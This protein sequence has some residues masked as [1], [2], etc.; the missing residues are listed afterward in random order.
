MIAKW[1]GERGYGGPVVVSGIWGR[2]EKVAP[3]GDAF[4]D[5]KEVADIGGFKRSAFDAGFLKQEGGIEETVELKAAAA[6]EH[7][8]DLSSALVL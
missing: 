5:G 7:G 6:G 4:D 3:G 1:S 2:V 8:A